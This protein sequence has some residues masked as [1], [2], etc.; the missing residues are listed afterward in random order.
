[1]TQ[2]TAA[3]F[4]ERAKQ[5]ELAA[6]LERQ[7]YHVTLEPTGEYWHFDLLAERGAER[8]AYE[9]RARSRLKA[10][11][12]EVAQLRAAA[13][14]AGVTDFRL[15]VVTPPRQ[16]EVIVE[17]IDTQLYSHLADETPEELDEL[18]SGTR[19]DGVT[20]VDFESVVVSP[21]GIHLRGHATV[22]LELNYGGGEERHGLTTGASVP[23]YFD[24]VLGHDLRISQ[25]N[26]LDL[27]TSEFDA[28]NF[29]D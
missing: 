1:M 28:G 2:I 15:V 21:S 27:D 24:V 25:V 7:G 29:E 20:D 12:I 22:E 10:S 3:D 4:L 9:I 19:V 17:G 11:A 23:L 16:I 14:R 6:D 26:E 18:S 8:I 5:E 13:K